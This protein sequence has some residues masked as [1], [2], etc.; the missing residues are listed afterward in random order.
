MACSM[1]KKGLLGA[2]LGAGALYLA[3]GTDAGSYVKT[4][5][6]RVR[7][8]VK[9]STPVPFEIDRAR[10]Q[11][12]ELEPAIK[13]NIENLARAQV[14]VEHLDREIIA[15]RAN[16]GT[17][18]KVLTA[19]R[20][21]L[22]SGDFKLAGNVT[23]TADEVKADLK[24]RWDHYQQVSS[25]LK[26]KEETLKAKQ[27]AVVAARQQ[28]QQ[29]AAAKQ[30]LATKL[31]GIEA[32]LKMIQS[33]KESNEFNF[34][35]SAL[36]RAKASVAELEKRLDVMA[37]TA[38]MEGKYSDTGIPVIIEPGRDV[39]KEMDA[40]FGPPAKTSGSPDKSL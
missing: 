26:D 30:A 34:D 40:E 6:H 1:I 20:S 7:A 15:I 10:D 17:E 21:S 36:A 39:L 29:M 4:A 2:T 35:D 16:L 25:L 18:K 31:A 33:T 28:L 32:R 12:A 27:K 24:H 22:D 3:F 8:N 11:I 5:F 38:E 23:Y 13:D 37:R 19:L 9:H 14:E